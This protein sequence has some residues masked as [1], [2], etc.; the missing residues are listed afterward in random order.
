MV[1]DDLAQLQLVGTMVVDE[2]K[3]HAARTSPDV[4]MV[5]N[6]PSLKSELESDGCDALPLT[7]EWVVLADVDLLRVVS[8]VV[9]RRLEPNTHEVN[10]LTEFDHHPGSWEVSDAPHVPWL[11]A[12]TQQVLRLAFWANV[13]DVVLGCHFRGC[14]QV[15]SFQAWGDDDCGATHWLLVAWLDYDLSAWLLVLLRWVLLRGSVLLWC[16]ILLWGVLLRLA[17]LLLWRV[18]LGCTILLL[19]RV[20][21][22]CTILLLW[23]VLLGRAILLLRRLTV[24]LLLR[25]VLLLLRWV[26]LWLAWLLVLLLG[27]LLVL[28]LV[29]LGWLL[30]WVRYGLGLGFWHGLSHR[31]RLF[32]HAGLWLSWLRLTRL[33]LLFRNWLGLLLI[34]RL[35]L[36][37]L[38]LTR[39]WLLLIAWLS[40]IG[41][42]LLSWCRLRLTRHWLRLTGLGLARL[43]LA[44]VRV[45]LIT[46]LSSLLLLVWIWLLVG[47][48]LGSR[49]GL[50]RV[51][52]LL[53]R[54]LL[55]LLGWVLLGLSVSWLARLHND[56]DVRLRLLRR[57]NYGDGRGAKIAWGWQLGRN[58]ERLQEDVSHALGEPNSDF[59]RL[60]SLVSVEPLER[61]VTHRVRSTVILVL[62][63]VVLNEDSVVHN[64]LCVAGRKPWACEV[65]Y[66]Q[67]DFFHGALNAP[68]KGEVNVE[69]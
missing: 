8:G 15:I 61:N 5:L 3:H 53:R 59:V 33:G 46:W 31:L 18:L 66:C 38:G 28:L 34:L 37:W 13:D 1:E 62:Y 6:V 39:L 50:S 65:R 29:L 68:R 26:L 9:A 57:D 25:G 69:S 42:G 30:R 51:A 63:F 52:W 55:G 64:N 40:C 19:R 11:L 47:L 48:R 27:W 21:L 35:G 36:S 45:S 10:V 44:R 58:L 17:V 7:G 12:G 20:L 54:I 60:T 67:K 32:G 56:G 14:V 23:R 41:L 43:W 49:L 24:L 4:E 2:I 16:A 22:G